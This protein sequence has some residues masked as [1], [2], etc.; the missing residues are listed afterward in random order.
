MMELLGRRLL[1]SAHTTARTVSISFAYPSILGWIRT[2]LL[3]AACVWPNFANCQTSSLG[4]HQAAIGSELKTVKLY[5]AG[6]LGL[7]SFQSGFFIS[8]EGHVLTVWSTVLDV[9]EIVAVTSD[10]RRLSAQVVGVDPNLELAVLQCNQPPPAYFSLDDSARA[11][12]GQRV[13]AISN[14]F[15]IAAGNEMSSIQKGSVMSITELRAK[16][17]NFQSVYQGPALVIDA[18]TNNPGAAGGALLNLQGQLLGMLG[19]ELRD[20]SANIWINYAVPVEQFK[21]SVNN[22]LAGKTIVRSQ[23]TRKA[24]DRPVSLANLGLVLIPNVLGKT[25]A[26]VDLVEPKSRAAIAGV[27]PDD[28]ILFV[29]SQR[30][31]SQTALMEELNSIDLGDPVLMM[32]QRGSEL[33]EVILQP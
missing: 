26:Y 1:S 8:Q 19:K 33:K 32:I 9:S 22:I 13:L 6:G 20:T 24:A 21:E 10:G 17:G 28:L 7:D 15:G 31:A 14:L 4:L 25:P 30:V 27:Q 18:M 16:R 3:L 12:P 23:V 5:G 11:Q 29:N 2:I